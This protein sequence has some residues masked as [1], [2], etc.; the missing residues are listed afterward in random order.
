MKNSTTT[1][2]YKIG[3]WSA[4]YILIIC[5]LL[6]MVNYMDRQVLSAVLEPM[7][8]DL[9]LTDTQA[10]SLQ[11]LFLLS[12]AFFSLPVSYLVDRWSRRKAI[13]FMAVFWSIFTYITGLGKSFIGVLLPRSMVGVGEAGFSAGGTAMLTAA[14]PPE[15]RGKVMGVF[16]L[17]IPLGAALGVMLGGAISAKYGGWRAPFMV[18]AVPGIILGILAYFMKDYK[19]VDHLDETGK[20]KGLVSS[21]VSLF[22]IPT[23]KWMFIGYGIRNIMNFSVLVWLSAFLMR[24]HNIAEDRAGVL[25]GMIMMMAIL[26][27]ILGGILSDAWQKKNRRA[28]MLLPV[29]GDILAAIVLITALS[30]DMKGAGY[31]IGLLWGAMVMLGTPALN[32]VSQDVVVPAVKGLSYGMTVFCMYVFGGGWAPI[33]VGRISD[34]MGGGAEGLKTAL[35]IVAF[36]GFIAAFFEWLGSRTYAADMDRVKGFVLESEK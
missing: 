4:H 13:A 9:G 21:A 33:I 35:I 25:S 16:N 7:K 3:G 19:T 17:V 18:F 26:G 24:S 28:R 2:E 34:A 8:L 22:K 12:I 1:R 29:I 14:Y 23:L 11:T 36:S 10:G 15:S 31:I 20:R 5:S 6:Y 30:L 32:V 27:A